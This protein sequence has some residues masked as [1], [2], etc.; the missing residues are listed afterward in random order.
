MGNKRRTYQEVKQTVEQA[1][2]KLA[3]KYQNFDGQPSYAYATGYLESL[4]VS[5]LA[6]LPA[7]KEQHYLELLEQK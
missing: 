4:V 6:D 1:V 2:V 7:A 3:N 5:M